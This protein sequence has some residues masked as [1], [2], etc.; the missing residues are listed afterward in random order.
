[1]NRSLA[2]IVGDLTR[3][4]SKAYFGDAWVLIITSVF[5]GSNAFCWGRPLHSFVVSYA[6][7]KLSGKG[8][9]RRGCCFVA[10][11]SQAIAFLMIIFYSYN[12]YSKRLDYVVIITTILLLAC[13][14]A[15]WES[16]VRI[17]L[18]PLEVAPGDS[19]VILW[20]GS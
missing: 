10:F 13:G 7:G 15:V 18:E 8:L 1:M 2:F 14:D 16:Q 3:D 17:C 11:F 5:Y 6:F 19:S 20:L 12:T 9:G 4:I